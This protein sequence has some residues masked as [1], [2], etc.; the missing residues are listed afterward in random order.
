[1]VLNTHEVPP[2]QM[3]APWIDPG[4]ATVVHGGLLRQPEARCPSVAEL[5]DALRPF[6][7]G[8][9]QVTAAMLE[10]VPAELRELRP[11]EAEL[12]TAW[13]RVVPSVPPPP[14]DEAG[15]DP[16]LGRTL[17][18][19]Y[20]LL[21]RLGQGG[22]GTVYEARTTD[23]SH[24]AIGAPGRSLQR[25]APAGHVQRSRSWRAASTRAALAVGW[26]RYCS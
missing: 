9:E 20:E 16:L 5:M 11:R 19:C 15:P 1:M 10:P 25:G 8:S 6:A 22:M 18:G 12:P 26:R 13:R 17:G 4:L 3:R 14:L 21:R 7:F 24:F 23:G 2:L